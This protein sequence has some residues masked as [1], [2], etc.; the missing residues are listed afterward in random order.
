MSG[1]RWSDDKKAWYFKNVVDAGVPRTSKKALEMMRER[2]GSAPSKAT[3]QYWTVPEEK[4][5]LQARTQ[6]YRKENIFVIVGNRLDSFRKHTPAGDQQVPIAEKDIIVRGVYQA[7]VKTMNSRISGFHAKGGDRKRNKALMSDC[8][9]L[10][11]DL[12]E[13]M[14]ESQNYNPETHDCE[15]LICGETLNLIEDK[16]HMD[17]IDPKGDNSLENASCVHADCNQMKSYL[18]MEELVELSRKVIARHGG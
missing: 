12:L 18:S 4:G 6:K 7:L 17:H 8:T 9:F 10:A 5:K 11:A 16:W 13:Y 3:L 1:K 15:C 14:Q 2:F